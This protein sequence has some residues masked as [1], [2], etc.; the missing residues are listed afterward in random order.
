MLWAEAGF[1]SRGAPERLAVD[2]QASLK[3]L[4]PRRCTRGAMVEPFVILAASS[5][6][7]SP[8]TRPVGGAGYAFLAAKLY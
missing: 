5:S 3:R 4:G 1:T 6:A 7:S 8:R 2:S